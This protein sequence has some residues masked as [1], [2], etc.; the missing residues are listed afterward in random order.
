MLQCSR[1]I[2]FQP[3]ILFPILNPQPSITTLEAK[4]VKFSPSKPTLPKHT[5]LIEFLILCLSITTLALSSAYGAKVHSLIPATARNATL[6]YAPG[7]R[8]GT[9][10]SDD[11]MLVFYVAAIPGF[12]IVMSGFGLVLAMKRLI[13][14]NY[15]IIVSVISVLGWFGQVGWW[16]GCELGDGKAAGES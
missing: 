1:G 5:I 16:L 11:S 4:E 15:S 6:E 10:Q 9:S 12:S 14:T 3:T 8:L 7:P 2:G 13:T